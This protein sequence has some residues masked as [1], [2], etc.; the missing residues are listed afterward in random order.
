MT[1]LAIYEK[2]DGKEDI[3]LAK[4]YKSDYVRLHFIKTFVSVTVAY[5]IILVMIGVYFSEY[6]IREAVN[7]NYKSYG[8]TI[9]GVYLILLAV[10]LTC[11]SF[12]YSYKYEAS[13]KR[14]AKYYKRLK[15]LEK[16]YQEEKNDN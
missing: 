16:M 4:Y 7:L 13:R 1:K 12:G 5:L 10:F 9:L 14:L 11:S 3:E 15:R 6:L 2:H 8:I